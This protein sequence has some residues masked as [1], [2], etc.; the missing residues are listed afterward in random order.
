MNEFDNLFNDFFNQPK[1]NPFSNE[2]KKIMEAIQGFRNSASDEELE[3]KIQTELG[4]P[5]EIQEYTQDGLNFKK[6]IWNTPHGQFIKV[7]V[8]DDID[9]EPVPRRKLVPKTKTLQEQLEEAVASDDFELA[10]IL[11]DQINGTKLKKVGRP[12]KSS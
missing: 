6:L 2:L 4:D 10:C 7:I 1:G 9:E 11:R 8:T 12:K 5:H 3:G